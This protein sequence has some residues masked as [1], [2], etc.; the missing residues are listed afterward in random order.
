M[1]N[2]DS[3]KIQSKNEL[4]LGHKIAMEDLKEGYTI[5]KY[6]VMNMVLVEEMK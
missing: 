4:P 3:T 2:D 1:E 6:G 5:I